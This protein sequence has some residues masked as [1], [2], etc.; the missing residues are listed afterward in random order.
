MTVLRDAEQAWVARFGTPFDYD[1]ERC[2]WFAIGWA[3]GRVSG[4]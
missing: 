4:E 3:D 1:I 2:R